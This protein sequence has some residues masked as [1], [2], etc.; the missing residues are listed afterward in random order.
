MADCDDT[1]RE[2]ERFL[3]TEL[4]PAAHNAIQE[5]LDGCMHCLHTFDFQAELR[6]VI[7]AKC[8]SDEMPP[9]LLD[10]IEACFGDLD[11]DL[12]SGTEDATA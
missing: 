10:K 7:S 2:I 9:G 6:E 11:A 5:H 1:L 12:A 3:D 4:S 8:R